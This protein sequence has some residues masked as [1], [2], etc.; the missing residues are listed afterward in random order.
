VDQVAGGAVLAQHLV[1]LAAHP[2]VARLELGLDPGAQRAERVVALAPRPL[3]VG[4]LVVAGG[5][6][7]GAGVAE[8]DLQ[9]PLARHVAAQ[10]AD[11]DGEL[12]L[13]VDV[14][15]AGRQRDRVPGPDHRGVRLEEHHRVGRR[16]AAHLGHVVGVVL[17]DADHLARQHGREQPHRRQRVHL[18]GELGGGER[19]PRHLRDDQVGGVAAADRRRGA[20]DDAERDVAADGVPGDA[21]AGTTSCCTGGR[22]GGHATAGATCARHR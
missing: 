7:V 3:P 16:L 13:V 5:D 22:G 8:H 19:V 2:Q 21:H 9:R 10:P 15:A 11:D 4:L 1:D 6:V 14:R 20:L 12:G 18:P 17:A